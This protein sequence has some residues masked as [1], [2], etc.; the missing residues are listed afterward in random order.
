MIDRV[1][2]SF[3]EP[4]ENFMKTESQNKITKQ[5]LM[6]RGAFNNMQKYNDCVNGLISL[7]DYTKE[8]EILNKESHQNYIKKW[9]NDSNARQ[10]F[11]NNFT[12]TIDQLIADIEY[13][14]SVH[15]FSMP[16]EK[17][18]KNSLIYTF[19]VNHGDT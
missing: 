9:S 5:L 18:V 16:T 11:L 13:L 8:C 3:N 17:I 2:K 7:D 6:V 4:N 1:H 10:W 12:D 15:K 19:G 14:T